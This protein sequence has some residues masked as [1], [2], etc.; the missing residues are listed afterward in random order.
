MLFQEL[1]SKVYLDMD[2]LI[3]NLFD[4][5]ALKLFKLHYKDISVEQKAEAKKLW[6][7]KQHFVDNFGDVKEFFANLPLFGDNG[8][9]T[10]AII[11]TVVGFAGEYRICSHPAGIDAA[12]CK[13]GKLDWIHAHLKPQPIE[14][15]FPQSKAVFAKQ[16]DSTPNILID[17]FPP[18][19][20]SWQ[21]A[22]GIAIHMRTDG[23]HS[24]K[25]VVDFLNENLNKAKEQ[26]EQQKE[27]K[28]DKTVE[29]L[30]QKF[31]VV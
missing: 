26:I 4:A 12:A 21:N 31:R 14:T 17:D 1:G 22:G 7:D 19:I 13:Q 29:S 3:A 2:G 20:E 11:T 18:Y 6:Y 24:I 30:V 28:F 25:E 16:Q 8:E 23:F 10:K 9:L 15:E 5:V 27:K